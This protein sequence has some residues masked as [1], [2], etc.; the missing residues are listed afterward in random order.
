LPASHRS[1]PLGQSVSL[2][3]HESQS[4]LWEDVIGRS[5]AFL[6]FLQPLLAAVSAGSFSPDPRALWERVNVVQPSLIRVDADE[7]TYSLHIVIRM[8]LELALLN[9]EL[10]VKELPSAWDDRYR[11]YLGVTAPSV[12]DG[13][14]QD[15]HWS[16]GLFGY[17]PTYTL[18]NLAAAQLFNAAAAQINDLESLIARGDFVP[19]LRWLHE[20]VHQQGRC[21]SGAELIQNATG[22]PLSPDHLMQYL[23]NKLRPL[24]GI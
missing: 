6:E 14:L 2:G 20:N 1:S 5:E 22:T 11:H 13:V 15:V 21:Y 12:K 3:I 10:S 9:D 17:F 8:E 16:A 23:E 19:L 24:Y 18:G 7:V 4:L